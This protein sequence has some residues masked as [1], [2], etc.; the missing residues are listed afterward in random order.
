MGEIVPVETE[1]SQS[2]QNVTLSL[3]EDLRYVS[4]PNI[5]LN[6]RKRQIY[7]ILFILLAITFETFASHSIYYTYIPYLVPKSSTVDNW[8]LFLYLVAYAVAFVTGFFTDKHLQRY[9]LI[10]AGYILYLAGYVTL[11]VISHDSACEIEQEDSESIHHCVIDVGSNFKDD[12][13]SCSLLIRDGKMNYIVNEKQVNCL[14]YLQGLRALL[15]PH[16]QFFSKNQ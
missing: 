8:N 12:E 6:S 9:W 3:P 11:Y 13:C 14:S 10:I 2:F 4:F 15:C 1:N 7:S 5:T 16:H